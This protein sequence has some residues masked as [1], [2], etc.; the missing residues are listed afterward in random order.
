MWASSSQL[1]VLLLLLL[2][3]TIVTPIGMSEAQCPAFDAMGTDEIERLFCRPPEIDPQGLPVLTVNG[4]CDGLLL[5][6]DAEAC[7]DS[8]AFNFDST[9]A[10]SSIKVTLGSSQCKFGGLELWSFP[11]R[12][13]NQQSSQLLQVVLKFSE[14]HHTS[15]S[16]VNTSEMT[17]SSSCAASGIALAVGLHA[18]SHQ[19][20]NLLQ[21]I[22]TV[23]AHHRLSSQKDSE[24]MQKL[25]CHMPA[26]QHFDYAMHYTYREVCVAT[27]SCHERT[28]AMETTTSTKLQCQQKCI[29]SLDLELKNPLDS[30][31]IGYMFSQIN[32]TAGSC[33]IYEGDSAMKETLVVT[34]R[35]PCV[36]N[37]LRLFSHTARQS[38]SRRL[39]GQAE[40]LDLSF[41]LKD[42]SA[43]AVVAEMVVVESDNSVHKI[44]DSGYHVY[45]LE[46]EDFPGALQTL[47]VSPDHLKRLMAWSRDFNPQKLARPFSAG[48]SQPLSVDV[49]ASCPHLFYCSW[50]FQTSYGYCIQWLHL[51]VLLFVVARTFQWAKTYGNYARLENSQ[52]C[53]SQ[54]WRCWCSLFE[55]IVGPKPSHRTS[56]RGYEPLSVTEGNPRKM[57]VAPMGAT[58]EEDF[59][60]DRGSSQAAEFSFDFLIHLF[61]ALSVVNLVLSLSQFIV[62]LSCHTM[63]TNVQ[64]LWELVASNFW[65]CLDIVSLGTVMAM[66]ASAVEERLIRVQV[67]VPGPERTV[68]VEVV[69]EV[70]HHSVADAPDAIHVFN[71]VVC[72]LSGASQHG[73]PFCTSNFGKAHCT[74]KVPTLV[75]DDMKHRHDLAG[76]MFESFQTPDAALTQRGEARWIKENSAR[77]VC[78]RGDDMQ[79]EVVISRNSQKRLES[80]TIPNA[81]FFERGL[82]SGQMESVLTVGD[83]LK[84]GLWITR[85]RA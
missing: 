58:Q 56:A 74:V 22:C 27:R 14:C 65:A 39:A 81:D 9:K 67:E 63:A 80:T 36:C 5:S 77:L 21:W 35:G 7:H 64:S 60:V 73:G 55:C 72:S 59:E 33:K 8:H 18:D 68:E 79:V 10:A 3:I 78:K 54:C 70:I 84:L 52:S 53:L 17:D 57:K 76:T 2:L 44:R 37:S 62:R 50:A 24:L 75:S 15:G 4:L 25:G 61:F 11:D 43:K 46:S 34:E 26:E 23:D 38:M 51:L 69:R 31:C 66:I 71:V 82:A 16:S 40:L 19:D 28:P 83:E 1:L 6:S 47:P 20:S 48:L 49:D 30:K 12:R 13:L 45:R 29:Q 41:L 32:S 42:T 85:I